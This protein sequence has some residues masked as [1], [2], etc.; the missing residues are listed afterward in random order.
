ML[1]INPTTKA[2]SLT[3]LVHLVTPDLAPR[4]L[5]GDFVYG[6]VVEET[7]VWRF[8]KKRGVSVNLSERVAGF[9][10]VCRFSV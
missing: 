8:D 1:Y 5:F 3:Q 4:K 10:R 7:E 2:V 9:A 6:D